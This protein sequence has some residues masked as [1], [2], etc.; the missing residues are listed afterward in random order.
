[1]C[2]R[3]NVC[4]YSLF[5]GGCGAQ[6]LSAMVMEFMLITWAFKLLIFRK[7]SFCL[8]AQ[9]IRYAHLFQF[10]IKPW[11]CYKFKIEC[12]LRRWWYCNWLRHVWMSLFWGLKFVLFGVGERSRGRIKQQILGIG[13]RDLIYQLHALSFIST[14]QQ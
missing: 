7:T 12:T 9:P 8:A 11:T 10:N 1:M 5:F 6:M 14:W 3:S 2:V 4:K 13:I